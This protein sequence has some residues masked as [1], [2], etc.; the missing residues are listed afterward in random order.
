ML[1]KPDENFIAERTNSLLDMPHNTLPTYIESET[2]H[3]LE[4]TPQTDFE[5]LQSYAYNYGNYLLDDPQYRV[6]ETTYITSRIL[7]TTL[8]EFTSP[9]AEQNVQ[10]IRGLRVLQ[11]SN[12]RQATKAYEH[13]I[14]PRLR[15]RM[16]QSHQ[17]G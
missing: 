3:I 17:P 6:F 14:S 16:N 12:L 11:R 15:M 8:L 10:A 1:I 2:D 13:L 5:S 7:T 4:T 9:F